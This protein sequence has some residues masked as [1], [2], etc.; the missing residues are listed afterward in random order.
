MSNP[1]ASPQATVSDYEHDETYEP[2]IFSTQGRIGRVRYFAYSCIVQ[3]IL[4][5]LVGIA[6]AV[7]IPALATSPENSTGVLLLIY[8]PLFAAAF[9]MAKRR[10]NDLNQTGWLSLLLVIPLINLIIAIYLMFWPGS[11]GS[12]KYGAAPTPN[13]GRVIL[14]GVAAPILAL[15][16]VGMLAAIAIPAYQDY[17]KRAKA[18]QAQQVLPKE[19]WQQSP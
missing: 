14:F 12:N 1:Y 6:A 18:G 13:S 9:V 19:T 15:A 17:V 5:A 7:L 10:L 4:I 8:I 2:K 3:F 16:I 11:K